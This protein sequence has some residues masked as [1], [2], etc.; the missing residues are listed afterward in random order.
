MF[1]REILDEPEATLFFADKVETLYP[2]F[3]QDRIRKIFK[4]IIDKPEM[5]TKMTCVL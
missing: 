1:I 2:Q 3:T 4:N 5:K